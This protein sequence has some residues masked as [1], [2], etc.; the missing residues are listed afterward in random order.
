MD[1]EIQRLYAQLDGVHDTL[2]QMTLLLNEMKLSLFDAI[3][4]QRALEG[5]VR[6]VEARVFK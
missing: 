5:R 4:Y 6:E 3:R 1:E 2:L